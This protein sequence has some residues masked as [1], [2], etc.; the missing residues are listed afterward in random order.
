MTSV[1]PHITS[2]I[3]FLW[4]SLYNS[5]VQGQWKSVRVGGVGL[6]LCQFACWV[7]SMTVLS[8]LLS[9]GIGLGYPNGQRTAEQIPGKASTA[10]TGGVCV[11]LSLSVLC[12]PC[13]RC[14]WNELFHTVCVACCMS[15]AALA[16]TGPVCEFYLCGAPSSNYDNFELNAH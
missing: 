11:C 10:A 2:S 14:L 13:V 4:M 12:S 15:S 5:F 9:L 6:R 16:A 3:Q 8:Y 1:R 7:K